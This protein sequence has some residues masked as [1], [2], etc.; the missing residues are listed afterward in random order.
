[1]AEAYK[2]LSQNGL[3]GFSIDE[4]TK[5]S[6]VSKTTIYRH[7]PTRAALIIDA[8]S[9]LGEEIDPPETGDVGRDL[10]VLLDAMVEQLQGAGWSV[11][12]PSIVEAAERDPA[13]AGMQQDLQRKFMGPFVA[14][15]ENAKARGELP[16]SAQP[17][18]VIAAIVGPLFYRRWFSREPIDTAV[19]RSIT[20]AALASAAD[21]S[22]A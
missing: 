6:G 1:M 17:S 12:Y 4:L 9:R 10:A 8:C 22:K 5:A 21:A 11:V 16:S 19:V 20:R 3:S 7:W 14:V 2:Q 18:D 13:I 15:I